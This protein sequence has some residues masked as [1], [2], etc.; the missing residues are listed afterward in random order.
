[1]EYLEMR[2]EVKL[3]DDADLPVVSQVLSKLVQN[4]DPPALL[5]RHAK[6]DKFG[7]LIVTPM[8]EPP[9]NTQRNYYETS[10]QF[11]SHEMGV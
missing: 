3:K 8:C 4:G 6:F 11:K 10:E 5:G 7:S 9:S 2:G 1:M